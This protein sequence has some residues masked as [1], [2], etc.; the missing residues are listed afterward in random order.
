MHR[1]DCGMHATHPPALHMG[2][3]PV[4]AFP[5]AQ[6]FEIWFKGG[7]SLSKGFGLMERFSEDLDLKM[8][9]GHVAGV[10]AGS[11]WK[12]D[13]TKATAERKDY[14]ERLTSAIKVPGATLLLKP[15]DQSWRGAN[16]QVTYPGKHL[17]DLSGVLRPFVL[18]EVG[19]ARATPAV[20]RARPRLLVHQ[21]CERLPLERERLESLHRLHDLARGGA[22]APGQPHD[23]SSSAPALSSSRSKRAISKL[24]IVSESLSVFSSQSSSANERRRVPKWRGVPV[25]TFSSLKCVRRTTGAPRSP[26]FTGGQSS[27]G[28]LMGRV[29]DAGTHRAHDKIPTARR[30]GSR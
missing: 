21:R 30:V 12:S 15:V 14:F 16:I 18:L 9:A 10:P 28:G 17:A 26:G 19:S 3:V 7:T 5:H 29:M 20:P 23:T 2:V 11:N 1:V 4:H 6:G 27:A 8:E 22:I 13:G 25:V 24:S